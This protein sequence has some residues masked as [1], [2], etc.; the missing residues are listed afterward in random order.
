MYGVASLAAIARVGA[1][2]AGQSTN[3]VS[4]VEV[5]S[6]THSSRRHLL[7]NHL[8]VFIDESLPLALLVAAEGLQ[9]EV[10][11]NVLFVVVVIHG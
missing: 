7:V 10:I 4:D 8:D 1:R 5:E 2:H 3:A 6:L 11:S 9:R